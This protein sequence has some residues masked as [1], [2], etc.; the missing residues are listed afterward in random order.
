[1]KVNKTIVKYQLLHVRLQ[2]LEKNGLLKLSEFLVNNDYKG[3]DKY[4]HNWAEK[5]HMSVTRAAY[6]FSKFEDDW[7]DLQTDVMEKNK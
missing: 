6:I 5:H 7:I 4:L 3:F 1:M 2:Q